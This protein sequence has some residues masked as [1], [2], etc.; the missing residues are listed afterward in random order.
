MSRYPLVALHEVLMTA[1]EPVSV[2]LQETYHTAGIYSF[3]RGLFARPPITGAETK[4]KTLFRIHHR[5]FIYSRLFAWEG[6]LAVVPS[7]FDGYHVS[8]EFPTFE[9]NPDRAEPSYLAW[10]C[11]WKPLW[12]SLQAGTRGLGLRRQRVHP[13]RLLAVEIPLP[14]IEEQRRLAERIDS[15]A[16]RLQA[17][18]VL[19]R[20]AGD[21]S[22]RLIGS[23]LSQFD[24]SAS[25]A[26]LAEVLSPAV[27]MVPVELSETYHPAGIYS[28]GRGLFARPPISGTETKYK[29]FFRLHTDQLV[30]SRLKAWE[31]AITVVPPEF[32]GMCVS[33]EYPTF[34][35]NRERAEPAY[36][37]WLCRWDAFW[38][39]LLAQSKGLGARRDRVHPERLLATQIPLPTLEEQ[40]R[41]TPIATTMDELDK[42]TRSF[43]ATFK[44]LEPS[45]IGAAIDGRL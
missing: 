20:T 35:M 32:Q 18:E 17:A 30:M 9:V 33:Q 5:Q 37:G 15:I 38:K 41:L 12:D 36:I 8:P 28:F 44:A 2:S 23:I 40:R 4:Y 45:I 31:G 43:D 34:D 19:R 13:D 29:T 16:Q 25:K 3:G 27:D 10:L 11:R 39:S 42:A 26:L 7:E 14:T 22:S 6:A 1:V 24:R 21:A